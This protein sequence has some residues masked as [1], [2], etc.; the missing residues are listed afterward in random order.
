MCAVF[1][2]FI[3]LRPPLYKVLSDELLITNFNQFQ[4]YFIYGDVTKKKQFAK[5]KKKVK[6]GLEKIKVKKKK[7][8][9]K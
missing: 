2:G 1:A 7:F 5:T 3:I 9:K 4:S 6:K 8:N